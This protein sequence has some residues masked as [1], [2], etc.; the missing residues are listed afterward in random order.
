M[1]LLG[2]VPG[3]HARRLEAVR[4]AVDGAVRGGRV[5][6][7]A[8][9]RHGQG[10]AAA[11]HRIK[12]SDRLLRNEKL[13][14]NHDA[15]FR[16]VAAGI[17]GDRDTV[18]VLIDWTHLDTHCALVAA[19]PH[20]GRS[21]PILFEVHEA[22]HY[23]NRDVQAE[24]LARLR[25][26]LP[27][28]CKPILVTDAG[29]RA[30][31]VKEAGEQGLAVVTRISGC[32]KL[33]SEGAWQTV[34]QIAAQAE[35]VPTDLGTVLLTTTNRLEV[36]AVRAARYVPPSPPRKPQLRKTGKKGY[37]EVKK[38][39][40]QPWVLATSLDIPASEV[41][42]LYALRMQIEEQ[43]RDHKSHR[44]GL[45]LRYTR[46]SSVVRRANLLLLASLVEFVLA[47]VGRIAEARGL[48][49]RFQANTIRN[50]RVLSLQFIARAMLDSCHHALVHAR[51]LK[52][53]LHCLQRA[54]HSLAPT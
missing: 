36:R 23:S 8:I 39:S 7:T 26:I 40:T 14:Q 13:F 44:F 6:L 15:F 24:F 30:P 11:K 43:F 41:V 48:P 19:V 20:S 28:A 16:A 25:R 46:A 1:V 12:R 34:D 3:V 53:E 49:R 21:V 54:V 18:V 31:W 27:D 29:F 52:R 17:V 22:R 2:R 5:G 51:S 42:R 10:S 45:S 50:R 35:A 9:G 47:V 32:S 37:A 38:A 33:G 4:W